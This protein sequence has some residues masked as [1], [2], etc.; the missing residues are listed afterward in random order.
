MEKYHYHRF[1]SSSSYILFL[2]SSRRYEV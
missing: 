2:E 1:S